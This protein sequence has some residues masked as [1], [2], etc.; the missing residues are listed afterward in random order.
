MRRQK[1]R[2]LRLDGSRGADLG[3]LLVQGLLECLVL[4][5]EEEAAIERE[6]DG[7]YDEEGEH[8]EV[9]GPLVVKRLVGEAAEERRQEA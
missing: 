3:S 5:C 1:D 8:V 4:G 2:G 7:C 6:V 9:H